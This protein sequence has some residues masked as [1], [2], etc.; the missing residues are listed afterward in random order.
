[1]F[2]R[3]T[4]S[5]NAVILKSR[6]KV[7]VADLKVYFIYFTSGFNYWNHFHV[8]W[9]IFAVVFPAPQVEFKKSFTCASI[10][11]NRLNPIL[12]APLKVTSGQGGAV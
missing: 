1:M 10:S 7:N 2:V 6:V 9:F 12:H 8:S 3:Q 5:Y 4:C 11:Y